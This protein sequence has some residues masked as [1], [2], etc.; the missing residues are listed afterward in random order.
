M[1]VRRGGVLPFVDP[2]VTARVHF[3]A[4]I[5]Q[6][7]AGGTGHPA[8]GEEHLVEGIA[9]FAVR[10]DQQNLAVAGRLELRQRVAEMR[11]Q[12]V[13][14]IVLEQIRGQF[15]IESLQQALAAHEQFHLAAQRLQH[16]AQFH[17]DVAAGE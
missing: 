7:E 3:H 14:A 2:H 8:G 16:A 15:V 12:A 4:G 9:A 5:L 6:T 11:A 13:L 17:R 1:D 10:I